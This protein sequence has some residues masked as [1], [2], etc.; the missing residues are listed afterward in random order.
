MAL[1]KLKVIEYTEENCCR[2]AERKFNIIENLWEAVFF[3]FNLILL[4]VIQFCFFI[5]QTC[6]GF[7]K[8]SPVLPLY[9]TVQHISYIIQFLYIDC[10]T[11]HNTLKTNDDQPTWAC[12]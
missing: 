4:T 8:P 7:V 1:F 2:V 11:L 5:L 10:Y 3:Y 9:A 12:I 6:L